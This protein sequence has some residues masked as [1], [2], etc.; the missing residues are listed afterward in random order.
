LP[1]DDEGF[2]DQAFSESVP[3]AVPESAEPKPDSK[4]S[5]LAKFDPNAPVTD[6]P[7]TEHDVIVRQALTVG[8]FETAVERC[9]ATDRM[10]DALV[11]S[12]CGGATLWE[13][14]R[15]SYFKQH[16]QPFIR[17]VMQLVIKQD[18]ATVVAES[19]LEAWK[20][21]LA[22]IITYTQGEQYRTLV[23]QLGA[24]LESANF[25]HPALLCYMCSSNAVRTV[26]IWGANPPCPAKVP[27]LPTL[28]NLSVVCRCR[29]AAIT[30]KLCTMLSRSSPRL[31]TRPRVRAS[32]RKLCRKST[33]STQAN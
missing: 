28:L 10:A 16:K 9:L 14:T 3:A 25:Q 24:R 19:K 1:E 17:N 32:R 22:I 33:V 30:Q 7:E 29:T 26:A 20:E 11:F 27:L 31:P 8:D 6:D 12:S 13:K 5:N 4:A 2:F 18:L 23:N 15:A 21:T